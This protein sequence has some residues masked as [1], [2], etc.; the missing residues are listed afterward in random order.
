MSDSLWPH[1]WQPTRLPRPWDSPSKNNWSGLP[2]PSPIHEKE[3]WKWSCS[4]MSDSSQP[5]GLQPTR[6]LH[7]WDFPGESTGVGCRCLLCISFYLLANTSGSHS[8]PNC[9]YFKCISKILGSLSFTT[10]ADT[11][12]QSVSSHLFINLCLFIHY[13]ADCATQCDKHDVLMNDNFCPQET[14]DL[15][16]WFLHRGVERNEEICIR[17]VQA[18]KIHTT[19]SPKVLSIP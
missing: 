13:F 7:P 14:Y 10:R 1:R 8:A 12:I 9:S 17:K 11:F 4:V 19:P 3:K 18:F 2:F 16:W 15:D 5:H 6:L